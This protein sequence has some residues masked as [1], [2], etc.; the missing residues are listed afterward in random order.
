VDQDGRRR[1][2]GVIATEPAV[3]KPLSPTSNPR[4]SIASG[5]RDAINK[6]LEANARSSA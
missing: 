6:S 2:G 3:A 1:G 4:F 5:I